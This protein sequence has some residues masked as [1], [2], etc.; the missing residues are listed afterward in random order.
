MMVKGC[1]SCTLVEAC[2]SGNSHWYQRKECASLSACPDVEQRGGRGVRLK[3]ISSQTKKGGVRHFITVHPD[4]AGINTNDYHTQRHGF[5]ITVSPLTLRL[6]FLHSS[7]H[8]LTN[9]ISFIAYCLPFMLE[10]T[11][12]GIRFL[13]CFVHCS[14]SS[15]QKSD[16]LVVDVPWRFFE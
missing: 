1:D 4:V 3:A 12:Y 8:Y 16:W 7:C 6:F 2:M 14:I 15:M 10:C 5:Y 9:F 11:F 13:L